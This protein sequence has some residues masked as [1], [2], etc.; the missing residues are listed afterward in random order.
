M[1]V[2]GG[3]GGGGGGEG[4]NPLICTEIRLSAHFLCAGGLSSSHRV[5]YKPIINTFSFEKLLFTTLFG[6]YFQEQILF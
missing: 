2:G 3:G 4:R 1:C 6:S 5:M